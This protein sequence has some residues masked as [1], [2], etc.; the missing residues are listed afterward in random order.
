MF[1]SKQTK[2][3][4]AFM[5]YNMDGVEQ[6]AKE[7]SFSESAHDDCWTFAV[8]D[9]KDS[10]A[11]AEFLSEQISKAKDS[12]NRKDA[13]DQAKAAARQEK[14][15]LA[16][17][18]RDKKIAEEGWMDEEADRKLLSLMA[19]EDNLE[20]W[21][22][23]AEIERMEAEAEQLRA[24]R[25]LEAQQRA[26][27]E[28]ER[29]KKLEEKEA[30]TQSKKDMA[31]YIEAL[32]REIASTEEEVAELELKNAPLRAEVLEAK[33]QADSMYQDYVDM[34]KELNKIIGGRLGQLLGE[35]DMDTMENSKASTQSAVEAEKERE[36]AARAALA[37][38]AG[39]TNAAG[40]LASLRQQY[41][42]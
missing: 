7:F 14:D 13:D 41:I 40:T 24:E 19:D 37:K 35:Y 30:A 17:R 20:E 15:A 2:V 4:R 8:K 1:D 31:K 22:R 18:E 27:R 12:H 39:A 9:S 29:V 6:S 32:K 3:T 5:L 36:K 42:D 38:S 11:W 25:Q 16:E 10:V 33:E 26:E 34:K 28:A 23:Y 21:D